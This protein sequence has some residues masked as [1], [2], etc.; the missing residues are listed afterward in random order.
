MR[1]RPW[2]VNL[3][4]MEF[5]GGEVQLEMRRSWADG[6][7]LAFAGYRNPGP[8]QPTNKRMNAR[9]REHLAADGR[10]QLSMARRV[11]IVAGERVITELLDH[12]PQRR[13]VENLA[14]IEAD[15]EGVDQIENL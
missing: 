14:L 2:V 11:A 4:A 3:S 10:V 8:T 12:T 13:L 1:C 5:R 7:R 15:A 6:V 9:L